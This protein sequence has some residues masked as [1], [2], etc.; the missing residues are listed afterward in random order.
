L[1]EALQAYRD[2]FA[3]RERLA[4]SDRA[5]GERQRELAVSYVKLA[6]VHLRLGDATQASIELRSG[7][8]IMT[9][10]LASAPDN[11]QWRK[12]ITW[13]DG[14]ITQLELQVR[15]TTKK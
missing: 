5:N 1:E 9:S 13:L 15:E 12:E 8:D 2:G 10:L 14:E 3:I 7:R 6:L 11:A 4:G